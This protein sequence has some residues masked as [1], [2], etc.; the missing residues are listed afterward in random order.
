M[1]TGFIKDTAGG[2]KMDDAGRPGPDEALM[3]IRAFAFDVDGVMTD[4]GIFADLTGEL[5]RTF[6][7][8]DG[9]G[10]RMAAMHG[11]HLGVITGGRSESI[12]KRFSTCGVKAED[13]YLG[14]RDKLEDFKDF[15]TRHGLEAHEVMFF[16]DDLPDAP[17][18]MACGCG[19]CPS[20]A[21]PEVKEI[22]DYVSPYP[23]GKGFVRYTVEMVMKMQG[24]WQLDVQQ[25]KRDF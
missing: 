1:N 15:C 18:M 7:S 22:A 9:F 14:S 10:L 24:K 16:G 25:Y 23:G 12:R 3:H 21:V 11:Y 5:F 2:R 8:K 13:V 17:V 19:A 4:G 20:D 6:D